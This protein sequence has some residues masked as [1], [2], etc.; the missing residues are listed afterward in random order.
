MVTFK[1]RDLMVALRP[2]VPTPER[3]I[4]FDPCE[5]SCAGGGD[6]GLDVADTNGCGDTD[7]GATDCGNTDC[8]ATDCGNTDCGNT[9]CGAT[10][11]GN[12]DCGNT[13]CGATDC[14]NTNCG[15][16][17]NPCTANPCTRN[18]CTDNPCTDNPCTENPTHCG[19]QF[20]G[21]C[22]T[23]CTNFSDECG[24][25]CTLICTNHDTCQ[26]TCLEG[27]CAFGSCQQTCLVASC[28]FE[29]CILG[30]GTHPICL[31]SAPPAFRGVQRAFQRPAFRPVRRRFQPH[32]VVSYPPAIAGMSAAQL[33]RLKSQ[34]RVAMKQVA[35]RENVLATAA[36]KRAVTPHTVEQVDALEKKLSQALDELRARRA[37]LKKA[38]EAKSKESGKKEQ[39]EPGESGRAVKGKKGG[40]Q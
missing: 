12:T 4:I 16:T 22:D 26:V 24:Q 15:C 3:P 38:A 21:V 2:G 27:T 29:S 13:D 17:D 32:C 8:G 23:G 25:G 30:G 31:E 14:G 5:P 28:R 1:I 34:L 18:A 7:C 6:G 10:N 20:S 11:C 35:Q 39:S 36:E 40:K 9:D 37:E 19:I 33:A